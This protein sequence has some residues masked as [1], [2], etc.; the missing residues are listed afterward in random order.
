[1]V[2]LFDQFGRPIAAKEARKPEARTIS[3][4]ALRDRWSEYPAQGLTPGRLAG[5]FKEAD[6]GDVRRQA[7][8]FEEMEE[9]DCHLA[10]QFQTRKLAVQGLGWEILPAD[11]SPKAKEAADLCRSAL[12][13]LDAWE[14]HVL[15]MLDALAKGYSL[16]EIGWDASSGQA[17]VTGLEWIHPKKVTF[18]NSMLPRLI[19]EEEPLGAELPPF[20]FVY[21]RYK[22]RSGYDTRAGIMRTCAWMYLFKNYGIKDWVTFAEVYGQPLRL[23]KYATGANKEEKDAL[24][25]AVRSLGTDAAGIISKSTEIEFVDAVKTGS[26]TVYEALVP[27]CDAQMSKAVLGQTLTSEAGGTKGQGSFALGKVHNEVRQDLVRADCLS[28]AKTVRRQILRPLVGYNLGWD[29]AVPQFRLLYEPPEDLAAV[30]EYYGTLIDRGLDVS[31]EHLSARFKIPLRTSGERPVVRP[32]QQP[33]ST[34]PAG[35]GPRQ[36]LKDTGPQ[37]SDLSDPAPGP[38]LDRLG[39]KLLAEAGI[40]DWGVEIFALLKASTSLEDF[41]DRIIALYGKLDTSALA[42]KLQQAMTL[43]DLAGRF[44]ASQR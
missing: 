20:K 9:K 37:D 15:D 27:W 8:L 10:S 14:D 43:A 28:L 29:V 2:T 32:G 33:E 13:G 6:G 16:L 11:K 30:A 19:T 39:G 34:P 7:E 5:I 40:E 1:M 36:A 41:R 17:A 22:A 18:W 21:H 31:Q 26:R 4:A 25:A 35:R 12:D 42:A 24:I 44:D 38:T 23:G 3:V